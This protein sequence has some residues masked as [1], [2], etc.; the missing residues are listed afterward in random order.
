MFPFAQTNLQLFCQMRTLEYSRE[1]IDHVRSVYNAIV[2]LFAAQHRGSGKP[3]LAHLTGTAS[4]LASRRAAVDEV[5]AGLMHAVYDAGDFGFEPVSG[6]TKRKAHWVKTLVGD[7]AAARIDAYVSL[8]WTQDGIAD[9]SQCWHS[10]SPTSRSAVRIALAN[11]LDDFS[12]EGMLQTIS[13]KNAKYLKAG[14]QETILNLAVLADWEDLQNRLRS[15]FGAF[16]LAAESLP[17]TSGHGFSQLQLPASAKLKFTHRLQ[18]I[19][20][21]GLRSLQRRLSR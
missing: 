13:N 20:A 16:N 9:L 11:L 15:E 7:G 1:E 17:P 2:P 3:F 18:S 4:I 5:I 12:D 10:L 8:P 19:L 14:L 21:R 6:Q